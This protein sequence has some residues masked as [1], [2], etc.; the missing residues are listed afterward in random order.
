MSENK[1]FKIFTELKEC[2]HNGDFQADL[3]DYLK[4]G[5]RKSLLELIKII[6]DEI[7]E[8]DLGQL[9]ERTSD[10]ITDVSV[11]EMTFGHKPK[12]GAKFFQNSPVDGY[13][14]ICV[15]SVEPEKKLRRTFDKFRDRPV[16]KKVWV[17]QVEVD[18]LS[19]VGCGDAEDG[20]VLISQ[21]ERFIGTV[22][23]DKFN[24]QIVDWQIA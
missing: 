5:C 23:R 4:H 7:D 6:A 3:D 2:Y 18:H 20:D 10:E 17:A 12:V 22:F 19:F 15:V 13:L 8:S 14:G 21:S 1:F 11:V 9:V 24:G 16:E